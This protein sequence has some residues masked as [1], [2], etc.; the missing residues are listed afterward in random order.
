MVSVTCFGGV[1][2]IGGNRILVE[3]EKSRLF[4]DFGKSYTQEKL[5]FDEPFLAPRELNNLRALDLLPPIPGIYEGDGEEYPLDGILISHPHMDHYDSVRMLKREYPIFCSPIGK[6]V[7]LARE[8]SSPR[9]C[10]GNLCKYTTRDGKAIESDLRDMPT[11]HPVHIGEMTATTH[12]V[13]HSIPGAVG[14]ILETSQGCIVYTGDIRLHGSAEEDT[15]RFVEMAAGCD[16]EVL[17]V[18]GTH[19]RDSKVE[20]ESEVGSKIGNIVSR[21]KGLIMAGFSLADSQRLR[22]FYEVARSS[23]RSLAISAKQ[24]YMIHQL[25]ASGF[26]TSVN[27]RDPSVLIFMREKR[28]I[29][30]FEAELREA[31]QSKIVSAN[32]IRERQDSVLLTASLFDMN[33]IAKIEPSVG[34]IYIHSASEPFEEEMEISYEKLHNWL[35]YLGVPL[36]QIHASG[37]AGPLDIKDIVSAISPAKLIPIHTSAPE[38]FKRF[39]SDMDIDVLLPSKNVPIEF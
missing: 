26:E 7:L 27:L 19:V 14:T 6:E 24:A 32:D 25:A 1:G 2:E 30:A 39:V 8:W 15:K 22:T 29:S 16:P 13:D 17:V 21:T 11:E 34:S 33:E 35:E 4:L 31:Y 5:Y 12:Y 38:L 3:D 37:H 18:E 20:S 23:G 9:N 10:L 36:V 28:R